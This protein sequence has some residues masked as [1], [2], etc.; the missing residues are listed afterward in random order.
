MLAASSSECGERTLALVYQ[1]AALAFT[2]Q[3]PSDP[4]ARRPHAP[5]S[6]PSVYHCG[7]SYNDECVK[8]FDPAAD[9]ANNESDA[10]RRLAVS[11]PIRHAM[12]HP[13]RG[14]PRSA[15]QRHTAPQST[16]RYMPLCNTPC[17][18][19]SQVALG[20]YMPL[21][22]SPCN[23]A[24]QV[25]LGL[26]CG[27]GGCIL[28]FIMIICIG[29]AHEKSGQS[30]T[31]PARITRQV[32]SVVTAIAACHRNCNANHVAREIHFET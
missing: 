10:N 11:S 23:V 25:A 8:V 16:R 18:V 32:T 2:G 21:C 12:P 17:N 26:L 24:S 1:Y 28:C 27:G 15:T 22:N 3:D 31:A 9:L 14:A 19:A 7:N 13:R 5:C 30:N 20:R 29:V 4:S 6:Q